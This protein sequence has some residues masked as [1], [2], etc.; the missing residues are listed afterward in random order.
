MTAET[1]YAKRRYVVSPG[2]GRVPV[3]SPIHC[4]YVAW[5]NAGDSAARVL[6]GTDDGH[7]D[8]LAPG[9]WDTIIAPPPPGGHRFA[10]GEAV[11][12]LRAVDNPVD[13]RVT[14]VQ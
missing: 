12:D 4:S 7:Y 5:R 9:S 6:T 10:P 3:V 2:D 13:V 1:K 11:F 8:D 14:F